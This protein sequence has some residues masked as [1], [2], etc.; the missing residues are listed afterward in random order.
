MQQGIHWYR[1][2]M[3]KPE[4]PIDISHHKEEDFQVW[5]LKSKS[6]GGI[7]V[8]PTDLALTS[9]AEFRTNL[10]SDSD[11]QYFNILII[12]FFTG[13]QFQWFKMLWKEVL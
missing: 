6:N 2:P 3:M 1:D 5:G 7:A 8:E 12:N 13:I 9:Q 11:L 4:S 10:E